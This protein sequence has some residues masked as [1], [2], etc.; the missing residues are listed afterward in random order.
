MY[1]TSRKP[2]QPVASP[3]SSS[4]PRPISPDKPPEE[5]QRVLCRLVC[6]SG[7]AASRAY[8]AGGRRQPTPA[9]ANPRNGGVEKALLAAGIPA[10]P[11]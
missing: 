1:L 5:E 7:N 8:P 4:R 11:R 3:G 9:P 10:Y 6:H 2:D